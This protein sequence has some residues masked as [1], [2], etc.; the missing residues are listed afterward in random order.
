MRLDLQC[1][2][3]C[4]IF[5]G[6]LLAVSAAFMAVTAMHLKLPSV[7]SIN[8]LLLPN[9]LGFGNQFAK[10]LM[11]KLCRELKELTVVDLKFIY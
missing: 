2:R 7:A 4:H 11:Q 9:E 3:I 10:E 8:Q 1:L 6:S 5:L